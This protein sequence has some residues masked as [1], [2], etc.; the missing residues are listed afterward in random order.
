MTDRSI[1]TLIKRANGGDSDACFQ[2]YQEYKTGAHVGMDETA[3]LRWLEKAIDLDHPT[4]QLIMCLSYLNAGRPKDAI[5]YLN[6]ASDNGNADAQNILGQLYFGNVCD[7]DAVPRD[8]DK[9]L[10]LLNES[11][12][13]GNPFAQLTLGKCYMI[14]DGVRRDPFLSRLWLE[15]AAEHNDEARMLLDEALVCRTPLN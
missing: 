4:A 11:A 3:A 5:A 15:K 9:A 13:N 2:L 6:L 8:T 1:Q 12:R 10:A 7:V 14:G